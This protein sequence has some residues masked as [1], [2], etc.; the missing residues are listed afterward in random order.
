MLDNWQRL[1]RLVMWRGMSINSFALSIG[2]SR[3]EVLYRIKRG[4]NGI[5]RDLASLIIAKYPEVSRSW[6][7]SGE[8]EMFVKDESRSGVPMYDTDIEYYLRQPGDYCAESFLDISL[9]RDCSFAARSY[10]SAMAAS[11]P[12]GSYVVLKETTPRELRPDTIYLLVSED[13]ALLRR[14]HGRAGSNALRLESDNGFDKKKMQRKELKAVY[15]VCGVIED[16]RNT[17]TRRYRRAGADTE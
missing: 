14:P 6:L 13:R 1:E 12:P 15:E 9:F 5:S 3:A 17:P 2:L 4:L 16:K 10:D 8:G 7:L 11:I